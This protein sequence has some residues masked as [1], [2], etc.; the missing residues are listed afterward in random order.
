MDILVDRNIINFDIWMGIMKTSLTTRIKEMEE[1]PEFGDI[2]LLFKRYIEKYVNRSLL[3]R[4][5][6]NLNDVN[7]KEMDFSNIMDTMYKKRGDMKTIKD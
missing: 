6:F 3:H 5:K 1:K 2:I 4:F 7:L